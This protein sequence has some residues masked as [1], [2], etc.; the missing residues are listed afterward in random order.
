[1]CCVKYC[2]WWNYGE[3]DQKILEQPT[4]WKSECLFCQQL[5]GTTR[6]I[7][8]T[9]QVFWYRLCRRFDFATSSRMWRY[10]YMG[11]QR[12]IRRQS[13]R[14]SR[15]GGSIL[16]NTCSCPEWDRCVPVLWL[17]A[18]P[19]VCHGHV[20]VLLGCP[21]LTTCLTKNLNFKMQSWIGGG[22]L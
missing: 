17:S 21:V 5:F 11:M 1:M 9:L 8:P 12:N 4:N 7:G 13:E 20:P 14:V 3:R 2:S 10:I 18:A 6:D 15:K 22:A 19:Q 16:D